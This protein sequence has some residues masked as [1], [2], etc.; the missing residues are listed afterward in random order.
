MAS[1]ENLSRLTEELK[2]RI[3]KVID[4]GAT[5]KQKQKIRQGSNFS[6]LKKLCDEDPII[7]K[8]LKE[9]NELTEF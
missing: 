4:S 6:K 5:E 3:N 7:Q 1:K 2:E 9:I 8:I